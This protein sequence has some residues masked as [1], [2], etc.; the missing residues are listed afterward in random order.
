MLLTVLS[1]G[2]YS[3]T[4]HELDSGINNGIC[5]HTVK[6]LVML[7]CLKVVFTASLIYKVATKTDT[8]FVCLNFIKY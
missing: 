6:Q 7:R 5:T 1:Y 4:C 3:S 8:I 2:T